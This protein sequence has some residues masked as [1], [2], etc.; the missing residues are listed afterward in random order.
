MY[1]FK[2]FPGVT[3]PDLHHWLDL[4]AEEVKPALRQNPGFPV[5]GLLCNDFKS[6]KVGLLSTYLFCRTYVK[7]NLSLLFSKK[8]EKTGK[9]H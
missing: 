7:Y 8:A 6:S 1:N 4:G 9:T 3:P 5:S 2:H